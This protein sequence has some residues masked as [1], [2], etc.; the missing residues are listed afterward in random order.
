MEFKEF[1]QSKNMDELLYED[2]QYTANL[3]FIKTELKFLKFLLK[4]YPFKNNIQ[5]LFE[6]IQLY[7]SEIEKFNNELNENLNEIRKHE[8]E[9][10]GMLE[11]DELNCD[12]FYVN[13]HQKLAATLFNYNRKY[14]DFKTGIYQYIIGITE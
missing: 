7:N 10:N 8:T 14:Q 1:N 12:N 11:C 2:A 9:L 4:T 3:N 6:R 5:N 13:K